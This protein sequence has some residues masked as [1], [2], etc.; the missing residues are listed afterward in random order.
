VDNIG[1]IFLANNRTSSERTKNINMKYHFIQEQIQNGMVEM[2]F[3]RSE[4]N[5][6]DPFTKNLGSEKFNF[7]SEIIMEGK[8]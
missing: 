3:I 5:H 8:D 1:Y 6:A 4:D 2:K 7:H